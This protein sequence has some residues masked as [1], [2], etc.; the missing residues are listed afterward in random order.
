MGRGGRTA[1]IL[2]LRGLHLVLVT[3]EDAESA[4][5]DR[6]VRRAAHPLLRHY[7]TAGDLQ[8]LW[9]ALHV[10][11]ARLPAFLVTQDGWLVD[12][13]A[14]PAIATLGPESVTVLL[15]SQLPDYLGAATAAIAAGF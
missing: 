8:R 11:P 10:R 2:G 1:R 4:A 9:P 7:L 3:G 14:A 5:W 12:W 13:F 6:A 15:A